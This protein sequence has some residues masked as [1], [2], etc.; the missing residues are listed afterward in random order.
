MRPN[1]KNGPKI[2]A[3]FSTFT[4]NQQDVAFA[5]TRRT[6]PLKINKFL[7]ISAFCKKISSLEGAAVTSPV[8]KH[9]DCRRQNEI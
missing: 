7:C 9:F 3:K 6:H 1:I 8:E 4:L 5:H 2:K